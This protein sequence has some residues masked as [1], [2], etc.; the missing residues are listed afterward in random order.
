MK[1]IRIA[2]FVTLAVA[3]LA[4]IPVGVRAASVASAPVAGL[5]GSG[6]LGTF[7]CYSCVFGAVGGSIGFPAVGDFLLERC[8]SVCAALM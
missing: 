3:V 1:K 7:A 5:E 8:Y 6:L 2:V 4:P